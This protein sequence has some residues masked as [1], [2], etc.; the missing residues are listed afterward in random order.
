MK[1]TLHGEPQLQTGGSPLKQ[2]QVSMSERKVRGINHK[3]KLAHW[4]PYQKCGSHLTTGH[5]LRWHVYWL[6]VY[7]PFFHHKILISLTERFKWKPCP[8][9]RPLLVVNVA[10]TQP[11]K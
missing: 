7:G 10:T 5:K 4:L 3:S 9:W 2:P 11:R 6:P 8:V 1:L